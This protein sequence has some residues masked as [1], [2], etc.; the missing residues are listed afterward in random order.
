MFEYNE[1]FNK[2][3]I[4]ILGVSYDEAKNNKL[5]MNIKFINEKAMCFLK[6]EFKDVVG[7]D[8][9]EVLPYF[10]EEICSNDY[11]ILEV[12]NDIT[13]IKF[14]EELIDF[15]KV[16]IQKIDNKNLIIYLE[17]SMSK[18]FFEHIAEKSNIF[19]I[20][21]KNDNYVYGSEEFKRLSKINDKYM[22]GLNQ[23]DFDGKNKDQDYY[24]GVQSFEYE[25][26]YYS[27]TI[28]K[29]GDNIYKLHKHGIYND[30]KLVGVIGIFEDILGKI[31]EDEEGK[32][33]SGI[34]D[35]V[36]EHIVVKDIN[37]VYL[38]C[39]K[40]F[41]NQFNLKKEE[42]IGK[43]AIEV[44]KLSK[45]IKNIVYADEEVIKSKKRVIYHQ[46]YMYD[47]KA[48]QYEIVK[49]PFF[50]SYG[51]LLGIVVTSSNVSY[52]HELE[53][54]RIEFFANLSHEL[55]TPLNLIFSSLQTIKALES[56]LLSKNNKLKKYIEVIDKNSK[57]LLKLVN[58]LID[59][60][61]LDCGVYK[62]NPKNQDI[63]R[64]IENISMAVA[65]FAKQND[66]TLTFDTNV[67]EKIMAIDSQK[68]ERTMLNIFSNSIKY[69]SFPGEIEVMLEDCGDTFN[70][71]VKD[72]GMGIPNDKIDTIFEKFNLIED[73]LRKSSEGSGIGLALV[74]KLVEIQGGKIEVK[75]KEGIGTEVVI[76]LP[77]K[78]LDDGNKINAT[79]YEEDDDE[80]LTRIN[81]E[82]SDIYT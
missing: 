11:N 64:F 58:N 7:Q 4:S 25:K 27:K 23:W 8:I 34:F 62:Y 80:L 42:I 3:P 51:N 79:H 26:K 68:L 67:E 71:R 6:K 20:K 60:T 63:V 33:L 29:L 59:T 40:S 65:E 61:K 41:L 13:F 10:K 16:T 5:N 70:I 35:E 45:F 14:V 9:F 46:R 24:N 17:T 43:K 2:M 75:S 57:R 53:R 38:E 82:F 15:I 28:C 77:I 66:I 44:D 39:N 1:V 31:S 55:R 78:A 52:R 76:K 47:N 19:F 72:A 73:R 49:Q 32:L 50:D 12:G 69:N 48:V 21:D 74:K 18:T 30:G 81:I 22:D 37:G 56:D 54:L 36:P